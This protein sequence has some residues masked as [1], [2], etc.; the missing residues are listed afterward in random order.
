[1]KNNKKIFIC[2]TEQ[3]GENIC[4][5]ILKRISTKN[6]IIDGVCGKESEK[7][8][9][10]KFID[11]SEFKSIGFFE[12]LLSLNKYIKMIKK[13]SDIII[14][15]KYNLVICIDSPDFNYNLAKSIRRKGFKNNII[16]IVAPTV[17][18]WRKKRALKFAKIY[19]EIFTLFSF[20]NK[21]FES[22]GLKTTFI[23][24][25][26]HY[27]Q[28]NSQKNKHFISLLPGSRKKEIEQ[29]FP[30]FELV[31]LY[32]FSNKHLNFTIFIPTLPH[33][34]EIIIKKTHHW[35]IKTIITTDL[36]KIEKYYK[37]VFASITCSGTASLEIAKRLIPQI[38]I[39]K[40]NFFTVV[41][42]SLFVKI[43]YANIINIINNKMIISEIVNFK[44]NKKNLLKSLKKLI[45]DDNFRNNQIV[46]I[47]K[48]LPIFENKHDPYTICEDR[49][50]KIISKAN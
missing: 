15:E 30:Y 6:Y 7:F 39:Y 27:L 37:N 24:H 3:S 2:C 29:L 10:N 41:L 17:W 35:K 49:I 38:V 34:K 45:H 8:I 48:N 43:K 19:N 4:Y 18:A 1:L 31:Y 25:P 23:G 20:E 9:N 36:N 13:L 14:K 44:L 42:F 50:N 46:Q 40:L 12:I 16:Q 47:K 21:Y 32:L 22:Q 33:L 28:N 11:I 5:N 26:I